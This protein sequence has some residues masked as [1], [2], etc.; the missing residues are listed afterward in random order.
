MQNSIITEISNSPEYKKIKK[1]EGHFVQQWKLTS[2]LISTITALVFVVTFVYLYSTK[3]NLAF[4]IVWIAMAGLVALL[5][6]LYFYFLAYNKKIARIV[7][8]EITEDFQLRFIKKYLELH[9]VSN[10]TLDSISTGSKF[11][12][13]ISALTNSHIYEKFI[14]GKVNG[15]PFSLGSVLDLT[16]QAIHSQT[17]AR[18]IDKRLAYYYRY[19][20]LMYDMKIDLD[21][22]EVWDIRFKE[23]KKRDFLSTNDLFYSSQRKRFSQNIKNKIIFLV[24][25]TRY[26]PV[27]KLTRRTQTLI[28]NTYD[29]ESMDDNNG[30]FSQLNL[31]KN[32][33]ILQTLYESIRHDAEQL[34]TCLHWVIDF[35]LQ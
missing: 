17:I 1:Y 10:I 23:V 4:L 25:K 16:S 28:L 18:S 35:E 29:L 31:F 14:N 8:N 5:G 32:A 13:D 30:R 20:I 6:A 24:S 7:N 22:K 3:L 27:I 21:A 15:V 2:S 12:M 9:N 26:I 19:L 34:I 33:N 11:N